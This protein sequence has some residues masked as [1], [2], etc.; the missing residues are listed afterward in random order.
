LD[1]KIVAV[2]EGLKANRVISG[3]GK[4]VVP[5]FID[6]HVH[7]ESSLLVPR[8]F[9]RMVAPRGLPPRSAIRTKLRT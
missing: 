4:W 3:K 7:V 2:E 5:G 8:N 6:A 9:D 1:G